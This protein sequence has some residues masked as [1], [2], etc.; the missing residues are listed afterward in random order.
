MT[1]ALV[2]FYLYNWELLD[3]KMNKIVYTAPE[4]YS[5]KP[6]LNLSNYILS[7]ETTNLISN[8]DIKRRFRGTRGRSSLRRHHM[9]RCVNYNSRK[10]KVPS[11]APL[12]DH[13]KQLTC[14]VF[15][16]RSIR[17]KC[18][19][20][21]EIILNRS[22]DICIL[23][24][25]W[26]GKEDDNAI[27]SD[28]TPQGYDFNHMPREQKMG[29]GVA[30]LSK[31]SL[32]L[33][34]ETRYQCSTFE[35]FDA[36]ATIGNK[37]FR[38]VSIY[39][40]E[41]HGV[42]VSSFLADFEDYLCGLQTKPHDFIICGDVN[43]HLDTPSD[44]ST[45]R[46]L[47]LLDSHNLYQMVN[48][49]THQSGHILDCVIVSSDVFK[50]MYPEITDIV[51][52][53][54]FWVEFSL[55][56]PKP[57]PVTKT[58][59][60]RKLNSI[61]VDSFKCDIVKSDFHV[62]A[63]E[64]S[65]IISQYD[66]NLSTLLDKHAP[67]IT[68]TVVIRPNTQWY[69]ANIRAAKVIKRRLERRLRKCNNVE[70]R[71]AYRKQCTHV[72][73]LCTE[74]KTEFLSNRIIECGS[75]QKRL[76]NLTKS[77]LGTNDPT[78]YPS[79]VSES[80]LP[81]VFS[82]FFINKIIKIR[83]DI[84]Y[85][86][87]VSISADIKKNIC[88]D[89]PENC[90]YVLNE[91]SSATQD[92]VRRLIMNSPSTSCPLDPIPTW[93]LKQ[94]LPELLPVLTQI[95]NLSMD[96]AEVPISL[97]RALV[98]PLLKKASLSPEE[99]KNYRPISNLSFVSKLIERLVSTRLNTYLSAHALVN[100][101]QSAYRMFHS[102]ETA[103]LRVQNDILTALNNKSSIALVL[104]DLSA[105]FD[106]IDHDI[107]LSRLKNNFGITGK[108]LGWIKSYLSDRSQRVV[109]N[110]IPSPD[111]E[112]KFGVPQGS[113]LGPLLFTLYMTPLADIV[114]QY[115]LYYH[116]YA[117]DSQLYVS[118]NPRSDVTNVFRNIE[119]C[120]SSVKSWMQTN[121]LKLNDSKTEYIY[122]CSKYFS[123][124]KPVYGIHVGDSEIRPQSCIRNLGA[125]FDKHM[126]LERFV[127]EKVKS[128]IF[129]LRNISRIRRYLTP[130]ATK[131]IIHAYVI[132]RIDYANSLLVGV[133]KSY[134]R[135]LQ[136]VQNY[137][138]RLIFKSSRRES[139]T[140]LLRSLHWLPIEFRITYKL[141]L[142]TFK[143][144]S[145]NAPV[146]L[147]ELLDIYVPSRQLRS[148]SSVLLSE[149]KTTNSFGDRSF[150]CAAP[151]LW[152]KLPIA[153]R[154]INNMRQFKKA[155]KTHLF[156]MYF[157]NDP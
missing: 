60:Y 83:N 58:Y 148:S 38:C 155:L 103:L 5:L 11:S 41:P 137:A 30:F 116:F 16:A 48:Q 140:P 40:P 126:T 87:L 42:N 25:T 46:F 26:L 153:I 138:A 33:K 123:E 1:I 149:H 96:Q 72:N 39:R 7:T 119:H 64:P 107:L 141:L 154:L 50:C 52:S 31:S 74:A 69:N 12:K 66:R 65:D 73:H 88:P 129:Y 135:R 43:F 108:A 134:L 132:S 9:Q 136:V 37:I 115:G 76:F 152:N 100:K 146:Y 22:I 20:I 106:T 36:L 105:A 14:A 68:K 59:V 79:N 131:L 4:L 49:P 91:F 47:A 125:F 127:N 34:P 121:L 81:I 130:E 102:T 29:G 147:S 53:D 78:K 6:K 95:I 110:N 17:N 24:E 18:T 90:D 143:C 80:Q 23:T 145:G 15:N 124:F 82:E 97:K 142:I 62:D 8:L 112:M 118:F 122:I 133:N 150:K 10:E 144:L 120:I 19:P 89:L 99:L 157:G 71:L 63:T 156:S 27:I 57:M 44:P 67:E 98:R 85:D 32:K 84:S 117:D 128:C 61:E 93:L 51:I 56:F 75:D 111:S 3:T 139:A 13:H 55:N 21:N 2:I 101:F 86:S 109:V 54:H 151:H 92:E 45:A 70:N 104:L 28:I 113:V 94:C 77:L 35:A 114:S